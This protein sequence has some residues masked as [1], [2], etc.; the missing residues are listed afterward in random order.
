MNHIIDESKSLG[1]R[2][3]LDNFTHALQEVSASSMGGAPFLVAYG[4]TFGLTGILSFLLSRDIVALIA[5]FQGVVALPLAFWLERRWGHGRLSAENPLKTLSAQLAVSQALALPLL[6]AAYSVEPGII[7]LA[8]AGLGG[9]HFLPYAWLQR[10]SIYGYLAA[11]VSLGSFGLQLLLGP[12]AFAIILL[13]VA[14]VYGITAVLVYRHARS[15]IL[16]AEPS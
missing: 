16:Q 8:L 12:A 9:M 3:T 6:I 15:L 2:P 10:T 7:P 1:K 14:I 13:Y 5:M 4:L 11:A